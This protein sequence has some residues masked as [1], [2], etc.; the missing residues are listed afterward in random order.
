MV[1]VRPAHLARR[2]V[3]GRAFSDSALLIQ[4]EGEYD[5]TGKWVD[6]DERVTDII[7]AQAPGGSRAL[8][9]RLSSEGAALERIR[10]FWVTGVTVRPVKTGEDEH[11]GDSIEFEG[12]RY[13]IQAVAVWATI[14]ECLGVREDPQS[15]EECE[16]EEPAPG[17]DDLPFL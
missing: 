10:S 8:M 17:P 9:R 3:E 2:P 13:R 14:T 15:E 11:R 1:L 4:Q 6:G 5:D 16:A 7:V 12:V